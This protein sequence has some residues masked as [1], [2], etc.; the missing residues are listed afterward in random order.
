MCRTTVGELDQSVVNSLIREEF[1]TF[2]GAC[3]YEI[4]RLVD[5]NHT[6][7]TQPLL[8][9]EFGGHR[10]PLQFAQPREQL[11]VNVVETS[12]T[13]NNHDIFFF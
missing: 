5:I 1:S 3:G 10:P 9:G 6:K 2:H 4:N 12:V 7:A 11:F 8:S 13:E